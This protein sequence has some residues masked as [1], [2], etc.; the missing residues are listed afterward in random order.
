[1]HMIPKGNSIYKEYKMT[2][3]SKRCQQCFDFVTNYG[4][5]MARCLILTARIRLP[6]P[7][8]NS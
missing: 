1:M 4:R 3:S 7:T 5:M 8:K 6:N 2:I